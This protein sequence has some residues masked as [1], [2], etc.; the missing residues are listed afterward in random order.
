M[1]YSRNLQEV[2]FE[3]HQT[4]KRFGFDKPFTQISVQGSG[5][6][7][8]KI[9]LILHGLAPVRQLVRLKPASHRL[10]CFW[11]PACKATGTVAPAEKGGMGNLKGEISRGCIKLECFFRKPS[12]GKFFFPGVQPAARHHPPGANPPLK[13]KPPAH[14]FGP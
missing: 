6:A 11:R 3:P 7:S 8:S 13:C 9:R 1:E 12:S 4:F 10:H 2:V 5:W 14:S